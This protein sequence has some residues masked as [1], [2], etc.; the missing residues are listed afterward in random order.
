M[1]SDIVF[2]C[3]L[4]NHSRAD[5]YVE[6]HYSAQSLVSCYTYIEPYYVSVQMVF[7]ILKSTL[8]MLPAGQCAQIRESLVFIVAPRR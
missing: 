3:L 2:L 6:C 7:P 5:V 4:I 8:Q 1:K